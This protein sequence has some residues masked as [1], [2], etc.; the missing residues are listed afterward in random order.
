MGVA[1]EVVAGIFEC[2]GKP[3]IDW[4]VMETLWIL[5]KRRECFMCSKGYQPQTDPKTGK[6]NAKCVKLAESTQYERRESGGFKYCKLGYYFDKRAK[7][8]KKTTTIYKQITNCKYMDKIDF[9][10]LSCIQCEDTF[11]RYI[12]G[13][14]GANLCKKSAGGK[15]GECYY[16]NYVTGAAGSGCRVGCQHG[17]G[18]YESDVVTSG[19]TQLKVCKFQGKPEFMNKPAELSGTQKI[20]IIVII[21]II[22]LAIIGFVVYKKITAPKDELDTFNDN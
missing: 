13:S 9:G 1:T 2:R 10:P 3:T 21:V 14:R 11:T 19:T 20:V 6:P 16:D 5:N 4:C 8:C 7:T 12:S 15:K 17:R 18:Y 22:L